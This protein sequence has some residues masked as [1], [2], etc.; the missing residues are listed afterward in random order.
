MKI[1]QTG[2]SDWEK[3]HSLNTILTHTYST[4]T[5]R[6]GFAG[7]AQYFYSTNKV[8]VWWTESVVTKDFNPEMDLPRVQT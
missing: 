2:F 6:S 5:G 7:A 1:R 3:A 8:K 4:V